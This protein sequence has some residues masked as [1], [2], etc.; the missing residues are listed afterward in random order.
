MTQKD[1]VKAHLQQYGSITSLEAFERYG[2]T[3]LSDIIFRI[4]RGKELTIFSKNR[5][6]KNRYGNT[7]NFSEYIL[8]RDG[9]EIE[10]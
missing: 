8:V 6:I 4:R 5:T 3:R 10:C 2:I 1:A 7:V 9:K